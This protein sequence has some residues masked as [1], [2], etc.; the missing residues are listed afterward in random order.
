MSSRRRSS[1]VAVH[2]DKGRGE[3]EGS[4]PLSGMLIL[5]LVLAGI[6]AIWINESR[7]SESADSKAEGGEAKEGGPR[8]IIFSPPIQ[9]S[10]NHHFPLHFLSYNNFS[11][12][13]TSKNTS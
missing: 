6:A 3:Q 2:A 5:L 13:Y 10:T 1:L 11:Y 7:V 4:V 12:H 9:P 8:I